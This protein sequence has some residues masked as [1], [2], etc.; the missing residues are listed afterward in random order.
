VTSEPGTRAP[1]PAERALIERLAGAV[2]AAYVRDNGDLGPA[3]GVGLV[4]YW[5]GSDPSHWAPVAYRITVEAAQEAAAAGRPQRL[6]GGEYAPVE[7]AAPNAYADDVL[8][9]PGEALLAHIESHDA[10]DLVDAYFDALIARLHAAWGV[11]VAF[12]RTDGSM[13]DGPGQVRPQLGPEAAVEWEARGWLPPPGGRVAAAPRADA[14]VLVSVPLPDGRTAAI[15]RVGPDPM[16]MLTLDLASPGYVGV[17]APV[18]VAGDDRVTVAGGLLPQ[19]A[20]AAQALDLHD[21]WHDATVAGALW[22]CALPH[23]NRGGYPPVVF[24]DAA[25]AEVAQ[26]D[27]APQAGPWLSV[28]LTSSGEGPEPTAAELAALQREW[29]AEAAAEDARVL[30]GARVP[31]LWDDALG[32]A[33]ALG[34]YDDDDAATTIELCAGEATRVETRD[35]SDW[36]LDDPEREAR[37]LLEQAVAMRG[38]DARAAGRAALE[39]VATALPAT[40]EGRDEAFLLVTGGDAWVAVWAD[41]RTHLEIRAGGAGAPPARLDLRRLPPRPGQGR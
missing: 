29:A 2:A 12:E 23:G 14:E 26:P 31:V 4:V 37:D 18:Q 15:Q 20:V 39:A 40:V 22:L 19:G 32:A 17:T 6:W 8:R 27:A 36:P 21:R 34:T 35:G 33:P 10:Y 16:P 1:D 11:P 24:R 28:S 7:L 38:G 25:G 9:A 5:D 3:I 30:D 13:Q 41:R